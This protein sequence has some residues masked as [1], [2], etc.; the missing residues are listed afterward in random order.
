MWL[1]ITL[2]V[3]DVCYGGVP[4]AQVSLIVDWNTPSTTLHT[5]PSIQVVSHHLL[6]KGSPIASRA[7]AST[8]E[9]KARN[10]RF[11][12]WFPYARAGN[13]LNL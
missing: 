5:E 13:E 7:W 9:L 12:G 10:A 6:M 4:D 1:F 3:W 8:A 2:L 11:A